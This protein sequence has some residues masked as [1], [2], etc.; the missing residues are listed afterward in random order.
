M[1]VHASNNL[2][3]G[4]DGCRDSLQTVLLLVECWSAGNGRGK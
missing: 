1:K 2:F 4:F 3:R